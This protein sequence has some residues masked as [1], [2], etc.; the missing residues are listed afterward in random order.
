MLIRLKVWVPTQKVLAV[1]EYNN[2]ELQHQKV[3][4]ATTVTGVTQT[5]VTEHKAER[6]Q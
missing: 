3:Y 6:K 1:F 4:S 5:K 2:C